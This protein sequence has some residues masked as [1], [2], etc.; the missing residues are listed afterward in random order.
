LIIWKDVP[1][2][3]NAD[4]KFFS[5]TKLLN[6]ISYAETIE[7]AFY[8]ASIIHPKT[9]QPLQKKEIPLLVKSFNDPQ[10]KGTVIS[11]GI[12][13]DPLIPCYIFKENL[14]LLKL[15][16]L[17][18]SFMVEDNIRDIFKELHYFKMKVDVIQNSA[19]SFSVCFFDKYDKIN[20]LI[21]NL[22]GKFKIEMH[23]DVSLFTIRHFNEKSIKKISNKRKLLLEQRT[24]KTVRLIFS[25]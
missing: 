8:G 11:K 3:L 9:L 6:R 24:E 14:I 22:E 17:D 4:P 12:N 1:G 13:I 21:K 5:N 20:D 10:S 25:N 19:I 16:S 23:K 2:L 15:S 7:L 18:F